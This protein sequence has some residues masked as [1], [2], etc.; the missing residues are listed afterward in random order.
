M[1]SAKSSETET[2]ASRSEV[3]P[4]PR[5]VRRTI[6]RI[7]EFFRLP[8]FFRNYATDSYDLFLRL[9]DV[10]A[11][12]VGAP[13]V[14]LCHPD[15]V[16]HVL[17]TNARNYVKGPDYQLL[18]PLIG[19]GII[20]SEGDL[21]TRQRRL[22]APE[23]RER[24]TARFLPLFHSEFDRLCERWRPAIERGEPIDVGAD[25]QSYALRVLGGALFQSDFDRVANAVGEAIELILSQATLRMISRGL[26]ASWL[27]TPG[28]RRS[29]AA[30]RWFDRIVLELITEGHGSHSHG[31]S[32][33]AK[34]GVDMVSR[35]LVATDPET[36]T[37]MSERQLID[38]VKTLIFAG[39]ETTGIAST[40]TVYALARYPHIRA[41]VVEEV[42]SVCGGQPVRPQD[43][44]RLVYL[45]QVMLESMRVYPPVPGVTR[46]ALADD[47]FEGIDIHAG[48][49]VTMQAY[50]IHRHPDF[51]PEPERF[52]PERF[53]PERIDR[54]EPYS[55]LPFLRGRRACLGEHFAM[56]EVLSTISSLLSRFE[57]ERVTDEEIGF[58]PIVTSRLDRPMTMH[59][60][61]RST[62]S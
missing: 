12:R 9:G 14:Y 24:E 6:P 53:A 32:P 2:I 20:V 31:D 29:R 61:P 33:I 17:R 60:R 55:Y 4:K 7:Q 26:L 41:R 37:R 62:R 47:N 19:D 18:R 50:T 58:R 45:R 49:S 27:P 43:L 5:F 59:V 34:S 54:I 36:G 35:M 3:R 38:E 39:H 57:L 28:N 46:T 44:S 1:D 15:L 23:F 48:E 52:D 51:W 16:R 56:L 13:S 10:F 40:F 42:D 30:E 21:W 22:L 11:R 8:R 25:L